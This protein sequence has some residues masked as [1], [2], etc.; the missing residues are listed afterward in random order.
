MNAFPLSV[1]LIVIRLVFG[2]RISNSIS[3]IYGFIR[4]PRFCYGF[5]Y[6]LSYSIET[7]RIAYGVW[8]ATGQ[9]SN[10]TWTGTRGRGPA[11]EAISARR[12]DSGEDLAMGM[13]RSSP[14]SHLRAEMAS[15][16]GPRPRVPV[17]VGFEHCPVAVHTPHAIRYVSIR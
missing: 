8:T 17:H 1:I 4:H 16:A 3:L 11:A 10:P 13:A 15:A 2:F 9:C 12:W 6:D 7:Y 14:K 5:I